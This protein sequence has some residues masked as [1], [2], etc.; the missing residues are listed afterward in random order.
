MEEL[1]NWPRS[2]EIQLDT[3]IWYQGIDDW[4]PAAELVEFNSVLGIQRLEDGQL[5]GLDKLDKPESKKNVVQAPNLESAARDSKFESSSSKKSNFRLTLIVLFPILIIIGLFQVSGYYDKQQTAIAAQRLELTEEQTRLQIV[6]ESIEK[7]Q[8][9]L[10][11]QLANILKEQKTALATRL[12][13]Q[14]EEKKMNDRLRIDAEKL[15]REQHATLQALRSQNE[16]KEADRVAQEK[17]EADQVAQVASQALIAC[18]RARVSFYEWQQFM[19]QDARDRANRRGQALMVALGRGGL[20]AV[21]AAGQQYDAITQKRSQEQLVH[22]STL[23]S[24]M[25]A[26]G[27][28]Y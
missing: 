19:R 1:N 28:K 24:R 15:Q 21:G 22:Q 20:S 16:K 25:T 8:N 6:A 13:Q 26:L 2:R 10:A 3:L 4:M 11:E 14:Q 27:C 5:E 18:Q 17:K 7:K 12:I 9:L 23:T